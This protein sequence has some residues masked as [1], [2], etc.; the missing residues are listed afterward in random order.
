MELD[1][2]ASHNSSIT[3]V[4]IEKQMSRILGHQDFS[5]STSLKKI[6]RF[7]ILETIHGRAD[8]IKAYTIATRVFGRNKN[9]DA[10]RDPIVRIQAGKLRQSLER[11][12]LLAGA[13]DPI[14]I[15][16]PKGA[17]VPTFARQQVVTC[18]DTPAASVSALT[19]GV[20]RDKPM[21]GL[22][23]LTNHS[24]DQKLFSF[25][26]GLME[27][28]SAELAMFRQFDVVDCQLPYQT[29][30][31]NETQIS[32]CVKLGAQYIL[33]G[34]LHKDKNLC[35]A[36][37]WLS[38]A[39]T[40]IRIWVDQYRDLNLP[41]EAL[42][43]QENIAQD[44]AASI[45]GEY[46]LVSRVMANR[47]D[48]TVSDT[49]STHD[50]ILY[51]YRFNRERSK[52]S[53]ITARD[54][55]ETV[56]KNQ[57]PRGLIW[58]LRA[59][60]EIANF[61][62]D[63]LYSNVSKTDIMAFALKGIELSPENH[64][65]Q[66]T[67]AWAHFQFDDLDYCLV[68]LKKSLELGPRCAYQLGVIAWDFCLCGDWE[69]G[70]PLLDRAIKTNPNYPT[71]WYLPYYLDYFRKKQYERAYRE[72]LRLNLADVFWDPLLKA[73]ALGM[74]GNLDKAKTALEDL[75]ALKPGFTS[76]SERIVR[77]LVKDAVTRK[78]ILKGLERVGACT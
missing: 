78:Q 49:I 76:E 41:E 22:V 17:Y 28:I 59:Q 51:F 60:L 16:I 47:L 7:I 65:A 57:P 75:L 53:W 10:S 64:V 72:S 62:V 50:A 1:I 74:M 73:A 8:T 12:Y 61:V 58:S 43:N 20:S 42:T 9:F 14:K 33:G 52:Q 48:D 32:S 31:A 54:A 11:Y 45:A 25:C 36:I 40:G 71:W 63:G 29:S 13:D 26:N 24:G 70:L 39:Q 34:S 55:L 35:K 68:Q 67:L 56:I 38:E 66:E 30:L 21:L 15:D 19:G 18:T 69:E 6:F 5:A 23:P 3:S 46:G 27:E 37:I 2:P 4:E 77:I 44:I